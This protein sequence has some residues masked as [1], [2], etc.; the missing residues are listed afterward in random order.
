M[1]MHSL[2]WCVNPGGVVV[3]ASAEC[4]SQSQR[5]GLRSL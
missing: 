5:D 3:L 1:F 4:V 2:T